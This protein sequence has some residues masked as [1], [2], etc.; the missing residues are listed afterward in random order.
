MKFTV[1][2][3]VLLKHLSV[4]NRAVA[5][6][7]TGSI[8]SC[9]LFRAEGGQLH[10]TAADEEMT[11]ST[12]FELP[13]IL[14][15]GVAC[16]PAKLLI[17]ALK[18]YP[19]IPLEFSLDE[20]HRQVRAS[21]DQGVKVGDFALQYESVSDFPAFPELD[22]ASQAELTMPGDMF[23]SGINHTLY[24]ASQGDG[25]GAENK[26]VRI[27]VCAEGMRFVTTD[28][29]R[30]P[31]YTLSE[32]TTEQPH[33]MFISYKAAQTIQSI[34]P[35]DDDAVQLQFDDSKLL[36]NTPTLQFVCQLMED[37]FPSYEMLLKPEFPDVLKVDTGLLLNAFR[38]VVP[39]SQGVHHLVGLEVKDNRLTMSADNDFY[40]SSARQSM[41]CTYDGQERSIYMNAEKVAEVV[42][43]IYSEFTVVRFSPEVN[44]VVF[45]PSEPEDEH[46]LYKVLVALNQ[47]S[48]SDFTS[49]NE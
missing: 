30:L 49:S 2:S 48:T 17:D 1:S 40:N 43:T 18:A 12:C 27:E 39:F 3:S 47:V 22:A 16:V 10:L 15:E 34:I 24:A 13:S 36:I 4:C 31:L 37:R 35:T 8:L 42:S 5:Q 33:I 11:I 23:V 28:A 9:I 19:D 20:E 6:K 26:G 32:Y 44:Q 45:E 7:G 29:F 14:E 46:V 38:Q 25:V 41:E 21:F